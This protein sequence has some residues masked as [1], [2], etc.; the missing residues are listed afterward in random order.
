MPR[1]DRLLFRIR[2]TAGA[3]EAISS[4]TRQPKVPPFSMRGV[5]VIAANPRDGSRLLRFWVKAPNTDP[6]IGTTRL[7]RARVRGSGAERQRGGLGP[8][9]SQTFALALS[10]AETYRNSSLHAERRELG[11][12]GVLFSANLL[13]LCSIEPKGAVAKKWG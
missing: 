12:R 1:A 7:A 3:Q 5:R 4:L 8:D 6:E 11:T 2:P 9:A 13:S 10:Q